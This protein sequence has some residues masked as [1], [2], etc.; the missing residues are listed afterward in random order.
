MRTPSERAT[1]NGGFL[2]GLSEY[3][4]AP[5]F[6][7]SV[8]TVD[9]AAVSHVDGVYTTLI[10]GHLVLA[11]EHRENLRARGLTDSEI[12]RNGYRSTPTDAFSSNVA[13]FLSRYD[14]RG[15]PGF[16][17]EHSWKMVNAGKGFLIPV[18][19]SRLRVRGFQVR[20]DE[21][22][23]RYLWLSSNGRPGGSSPGSPIH[24]AHPERIREQKT[25]IITEGA[26]KAD[27]IA[28]ILNCGVIAF[29]GVHF[30]GGFG[31][32]LK[33]VFPEILGVSVAF[34]SDFRTNPA[35][36]RATFR[37]LGEL[38]FAGLQTSILTWPAEFK[39]MDDYLVR[40]AA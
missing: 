23:P 20:R 28:S 30:P 33:K 5:V 19:D 3:T 1:R 27:V 38:R 22:S 24:F 31:A 11:E 37:L 4:P 35:V 34:D 9:R 18:R 6:K 10:R 2:H 15:V 8:P 13:R 17:N 21:G 12:D 26:L 14:L 25:A 40:K 7:P 32:K 16:Y 39:G 36:N 29:G